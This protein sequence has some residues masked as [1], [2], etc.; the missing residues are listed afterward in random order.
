MVGLFHKVALWG[1]FFFWAENIR[2]F[3]VYVRSDTVPKAL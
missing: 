1:V 3:V 2:A